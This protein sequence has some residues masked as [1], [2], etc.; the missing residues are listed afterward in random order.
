LKR[1]VLIAAAA[2]GCVAFLLA[3]RTATSAEP[4]AAPRVTEQAVVLEN[5]ICR[6]EIGA[7][8]KNRA[9]LNLADTQDYAQPGVPFMVAGQGQKTFAAAK[10][11]LNGDVVTVS[12]VDCPCQLPAKVEIRPRCF[13]LTVIARPQDCSNSEKLLNLYLLR[14]RCLGTGRRPDKP[15][16]RMIRTCI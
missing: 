7:D 13:T 12:F 11:E 9:L 14:P 6:Y 4:A 3:A 10:V 2:F 1:C 16:G 8:G 15:A 5:E